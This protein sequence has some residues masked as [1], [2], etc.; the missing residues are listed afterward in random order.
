[1]KAFPVGNIRQHILWQQCTL[2]A[3][4]NAAVRHHYRSVCVDVVLHHLESVMIV[5]VAKHADVTHLTWP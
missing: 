1:V 4:A 5:T 3:T 2:L